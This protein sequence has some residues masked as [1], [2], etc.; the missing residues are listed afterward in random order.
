MPYGSARMVE[1]VVLP[2]AMARD[3][4]D[5]SRDRHLALSPVAK[6]SDL[7]QSARGVAQP[8]AITAAEGRR[9]RSGCIDVS[10]PHFDDLH[11]HLETVVRHDVGGRDLVGVA[12]LPVGVWQVERSTRFV[13]SVRLPGGNHRAE[14]VADAVAAAITTLPKQLTRSLTWDQGASDGP[15][16]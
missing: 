6:H 2:T 7:P 3:R 15:A 13:M 4:S 5:A 10:A 9:V 8:G 16:S 1:T 14:A 11:L 12:R